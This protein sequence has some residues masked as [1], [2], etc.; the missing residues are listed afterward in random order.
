MGS[1][2]TGEIVRPSVLRNFS[3]CSWVI[4]RGLW[5]RPS[6]TVAQVAKCTDQAGDGRWETACQLPHMRVGMTYKRPS[7]YPHSAGSEGRCQPPY[8]SHDEIQDDSDPQERRT[9]HS[10]GSGAK[11]CIAS[12]R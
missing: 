7:P 5:R 4:S 12:Q 10:E 8:F 9:A 6:R 2:W 3:R 1:S 11:T